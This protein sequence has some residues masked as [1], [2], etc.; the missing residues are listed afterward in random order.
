MTDKNTTEAVTVTVKASIGNEMI[1]IGIPP[2]PA[3]LERI[4]GE[5]R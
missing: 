5:M 2:R 3:V 4:E 1:A